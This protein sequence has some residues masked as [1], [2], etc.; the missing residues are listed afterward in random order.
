MTM[1]FN[2]RM[3]HLIAGLVGENETLYMTDAAY[4]AAIQETAMI[5]LELGDFIA[6][7]RMEKVS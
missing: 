5:M 4:H 2:N 3:K 6:E 1:D 7:K